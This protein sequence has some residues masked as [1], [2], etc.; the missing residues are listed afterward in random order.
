M[1]TV[2]T[3]LD[4]GV[5]R[6]GRQCLGSILARLDRAGTARESGLALDVDLDCG[7]RC[8]EMRVCVSISVFISLKRME[9]MPIHSSTLFT[10]R[11]SPWPLFSW[12]R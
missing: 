12:Q 3:P 5:V 10:H 11:P 1:E 6:L 4:V 8:W 2:E 9:L 7:R